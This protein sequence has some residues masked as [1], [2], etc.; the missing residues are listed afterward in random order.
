[1]A[2]GN[3]VKFRSGTFADMPKSGKDGDTL[4]FASHNENGLGGLWLGDTLI[5]SEVVNAAV[6][7]DTLI[8]TKMTA[9]GA[10]V[11]VTFSLSD[12]TAL[13]ND[14]STKLNDV[15]T[16]LNDLDTSVSTKF[17]L[18]ESMLDTNLNAQQATSQKLADI[19]ASID[20]LDASVNLL[21]EN[22]VD[23]A[24]G[25][26]LFSADQSTKLDGIETGAQVNKLEAVKLNNDFVTIQTDETHGKYVDLGAIATSTAVEQAKE[27]ASAAM[28]EARKHTSVVEGASNEY[29]SVSAS[30]NPNTAGGTEYVVDDAVLTTKIEEIDASIDNLE[31]GLADASTW[32]ASKLND[33][34]TDSSVSIVEVT[35]SGDILKGYQIMQGETVVGTVNIPKDMVATQGAVVYC[36]KSGDPATYTEVPSTTEGA[37]ACIKMTVGNG[38]TTD[39]FYVEVADL[40]E[41]NGVQSTDEITLSD[42]GH[43]ISA[44]VGDIAATKI[45]Y[46]PA[47]EGGAARQSVKDALDDLYS[48][49]GEG[50]SVASQIQEAIENLDSSVSATAVAADSSTVNV[51]TKVVEEDGVLSS[52]EE[53]SVDKAGHAAWLISELDASV[54]V[55]TNETGK[56]AVVTGVEEVDGVVTSLASTNVYTTDYIDNLVG[57]LDSSVTASG[58]AANGGQA[59]VLGKVAQTAGALDQANSTSVEVFTAAQSKELK[60]ALTW[61]GFTA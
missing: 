8:I 53:V 23:K 46:T 51:L 45:T 43:V 40:I 39:S 30:A 11:E 5:S 2:T 6:N 15:S 16:R 35:G 20:R 12:I 17:G 31:Q 26:S 24:E 28:A 36:T 56:V 25:Y 38:N 52:K 32:F 14:V 48:Q 55:S 42:A 4:Y 50:G 47:V 19:D 58:T 33:V 59:F 57:G 49:I 37:I 27:D 29:V 7:G 13:I 1:M 44:T 61:G 41:Y 10:P 3:L 60:D 21:E 22:K 9:A 54:N 34:S 18:F